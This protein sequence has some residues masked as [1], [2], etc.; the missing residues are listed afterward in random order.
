MVQGLKQKLN[1]HANVNLYLKTFYSE[2]NWKMCKI[3]NIVTNI[4]LDF[5]YNEIYYKSEV[6]FEY[7]SK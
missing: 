4:N 7:E 5:I 1:Y 6:P 3:N 2:K